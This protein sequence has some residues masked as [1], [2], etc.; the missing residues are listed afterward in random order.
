MKCSSHYSAPAFIFSELKTFNPAI[1]VIIIR[2]SPLLL[3]G[4]DFVFFYWNMFW[5][6][7]MMNSCMHTIAYLFSIL[8]VS[9][10]DLWT[11]CHFGLNLK[12]SRFLLPFNCLIQYYFMFI[13]MVMQLINT[14]KSWFWQKTAHIPK[15]SK[16]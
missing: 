16:F 15:I 13:A 5:I 7:Y 3:I 12:E 9:S 10:F 8:C 6:F 11:Q 4:S 14:S 2:N 1:K